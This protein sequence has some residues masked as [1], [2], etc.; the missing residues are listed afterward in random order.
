LFAAVI[1]VEQ[2][3]E[4]LNSELADSAIDVEVVA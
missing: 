1:A 2:L 4:K 3:I